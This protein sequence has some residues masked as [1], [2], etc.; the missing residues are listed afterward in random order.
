LTNTNGD[1]FETTVEGLLPGAF[2]AGDMA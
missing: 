2:Q 1:E